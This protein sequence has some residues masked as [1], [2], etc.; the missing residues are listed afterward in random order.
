[1]LFAVGVSRAAWPPRAAPMEEQR[2]RNP[3]A[4][5]TVSSAP[6]PAA[7]LVTAEGL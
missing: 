1:M 6:L 7:L 3:H 4:W 2:L 5:P